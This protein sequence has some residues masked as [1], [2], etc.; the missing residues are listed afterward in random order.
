MRY[1]EDMIS[2]LDGI[3]GGLGH[4]N[5]TLVNTPT[6]NDRLFLDLFDKAVKA[7]TDSGRLK[8]ESV[9]LMNRGETEEEFALGIELNNMS[10][11]K[12]RE[13]NK[14]RL[15]IVQLLRIIS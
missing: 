4:L 2:A 5:E 3:R 13:W 15:L 8:S 9:W 12:W 11:D 1:I 10:T 14:C 7:A 6:I